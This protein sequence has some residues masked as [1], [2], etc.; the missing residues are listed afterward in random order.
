MGKSGISFPSV[1]KCA[2]TRT[3][4]RCLAPLG[5]HKTAAIFYIG[6]TMETRRSVVGRLL[7]PL[8]P[9]GVCLALLFPLKAPGADCGGGLNHFQH[10]GWTLADGAPPDIWALAQSPDGYL[11]LGTGA[12][13]YRFDGV[14]FEP[15][16]PTRGAAF[17]AIDITAL[18][19][20]KAGE[21]WIG[22]QSGGA[23]VLRDGQLTNYIDGL[24]RAPIHQFA[25]DQEGRIWLTSDAG[26]A[27]FSAGEWHAIGNHWSSP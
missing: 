24:P 20:G 4:R 5:V 22:Y 3:S 17:P 12:G 18:L 9:I 21:L 8:T 16:R 15:V 1:A 26:M 11:W 27:E 14:R 7:A 25:Q 2:I 13:L 10:T 6:A 23:S 19:V